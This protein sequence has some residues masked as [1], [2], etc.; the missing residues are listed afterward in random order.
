MKATLENIWD[1]VE[2][3]PIEKWEVEEGY[4]RGKWQVMFI[5]DVDNVVHAVM[6]CDGLFFAG[7]T[8]ENCSFFVGEYECEVEVQWA[9]IYYEFI[10]LFKKEFG[11]VA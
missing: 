1:F 9:D 11:Y 2:K 4:R 7:K 3:Q 6:L 8:I 5:I 10:Q